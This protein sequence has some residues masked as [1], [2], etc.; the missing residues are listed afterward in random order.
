MK[1]EAWFHLTAPLPYLCILLLTLLVVPAVGL[2][3]PIYDTHAAVAFE[4]PVTLAVFDAAQVGRQFLR[5]MNL[6][7]IIDPP[8]CALAGLR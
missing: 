1:I 8:W 5:R 6:L 4:F 7:S 2:R 3:V